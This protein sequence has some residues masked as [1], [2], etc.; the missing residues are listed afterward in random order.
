MKKCFKTNTGNAEKQDKL[1]DVKRTCTVH[2][3]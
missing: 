1:R 2:D 3:V